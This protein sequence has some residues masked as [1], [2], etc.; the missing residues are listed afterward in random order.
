MS[1]ITRKQVEEMCTILNN[2][3]GLPTE[4]YLKDP[5]NDTFI[6]QIG[7]IH[8]NAQNGAYN[9]DQMY[10]EAGGVTDLA[11]SLTLREAFDYVSAAIDGV[12]L[13]N[14]YC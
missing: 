13:A 9:I 4:C 6:A 8:L 11:Y 14:K 7:C 5:V 10:N 3:L 1:R 2:T 12:R